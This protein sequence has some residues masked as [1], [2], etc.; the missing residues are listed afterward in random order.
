MFDL[1][2]PT[3]ARLHAVL[4]DVAPMGYGSLTHKFFKGIHTFYWRGWNDLLYGIYAIDYK[5]G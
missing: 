2:K 5:H 1:P 3:N 4:I